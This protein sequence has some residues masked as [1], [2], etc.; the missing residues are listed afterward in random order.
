MPQ[1]EPR[2]ITSATIAYICHDM[3]GLDHW[4]PDW[5]HDDDLLGALTNCGSLLEVAYLIGAYRYMERVTAESYH[6]ALPPAFGTT[7]ALDQTV[8]RGVW[9]MEPWY[10]FGA[11][12]GPS[13]MAF[14][15]QYPVGRYRADFALV[16][17]NDN[18]SPRWSLYALIEVNGYA[19]H[20]AR[21]R[22]DERRAF[23]IEQSSTVPV[24]QFFEETDDPLN[25][26]RWV[27]AHYHG[28]ATG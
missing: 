15:P 6:V 25:W 24:L 7:I 18:G 14:I 5:D 17:G 23:A 21:R 8:Y 11:G 20:R 1:T 26:F 4:R 19:V 10:G 16:T 9:F 27:I 3:L 28:E 13:A 12:G 2:R 22:Q